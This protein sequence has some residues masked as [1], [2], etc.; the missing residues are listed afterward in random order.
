MGKTKGLSMPKNESKYSEAKSRVKPLKNE[1]IPLIRRYLFNGFMAM[2]MEGKQLRTK[3][4]LT[5]LDVV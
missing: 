5:L 3:I 2:L 1:K 4:T